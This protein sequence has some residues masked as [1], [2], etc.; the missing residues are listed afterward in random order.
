MKSG[1]KQ[2]NQDITGKAKEKKNKKAG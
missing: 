2:G 1:K